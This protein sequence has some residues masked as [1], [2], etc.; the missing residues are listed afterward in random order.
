MK[1]RWIVMQELEDTNVAIPY[2]IVK[3]LKQAEKMCTK[4]EKRNPGFIF[5]VHPCKEKK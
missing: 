5:W 4:E 1:R 3:T 2:R